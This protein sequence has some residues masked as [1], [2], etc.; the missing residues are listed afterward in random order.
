[1]KW[2]VRISSWRERVDYT[3]HSL[4]SFSVCDIRSVERSLSLWVGFCRCVWGWQGGFMAAWLS[5]RAEWLS[6]ARVCINVCM[7]SPCKC[8]SVCIWMYL[9]G[10]VSCSLRNR[11]KYHYWSYIL[12]YVLSIL[13]KFSCC[14]GKSDVYVS[15]REY[16]CV[17]TH[18]CISAHKH[19][20]EAPFYNLYFMLAW[21]AVGGMAF[22]LLGR[23]W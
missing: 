1:M 4:N 14:P 6:H 8:V 5:G 10:L 23:Q 22:V 13:T 16:M 21:W 19:V 20:S 7:Y 9:C 3:K 17:C 18:I 12:R 2:Y 11:I 15:T